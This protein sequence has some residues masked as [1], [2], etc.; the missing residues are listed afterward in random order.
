MPIIE[1]REIKDA[2]PKRSR[3]M[4]IDHGS[5]TWGLAIADTNHSIATPLKTIRRTKFKNDIVELAKIC[6]EYDVAGFIIGL[7]LNMDGTSGPRV[8]SVKHFG[9]NLIN[10]AEILGFEPLIAFHDERMSTQEMETFLIDKIDMSRK[11]R[12]EV[13]DKMAAQTILQGALDTINRG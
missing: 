9:L 7:P 6:K 13:I 5:K 8:D 12:K 10:A 11:R 1:L 2:L 3:L 4:G